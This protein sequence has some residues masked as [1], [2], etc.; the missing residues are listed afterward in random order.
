M[1]GPINVKSH[2]NASK[3]QMGF[4]SAFKGLTTAVT[5]TS[6]FTVID[7]FL[8]YETVPQQL[9][10][11]SGNARFQ[12]FAVKYFRIALF[13]AITQRVMVSGKHIGS[14]FNGQE[15]LDV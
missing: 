2:N 3:W 11:R 8:C 5:D 1:H 13:W 15:Y 9:V 12:T 4:N 10:R 14:I 7:W 6:L